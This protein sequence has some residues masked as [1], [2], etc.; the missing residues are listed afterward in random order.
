[1]MGEL[2]ELHWRGFNSLHSFCFDG[3]YYAGFE[4]SERQCVHDMANPSQSLNRDCKAFDSNGRLIHDNCPAD[5]RGPDYCRLPLCKDNQ[6]PGC[7][8]PHRNSTVLSHWFYL[9]SRGAQSTNALQCR[10][11]VKPLDPDPVRSAKQ[12]ARILF[13]SMTEYLFDP[14]TGYEGLAHA[15]IDM[16]KETFA[17]EPAKVRSVVE[18]WY[19]VNVIQESFFEAMA[20]DVRPPREER[21]VYPWIKFEWPAGDLEMS[22]DFEISGDMHSYQASNIGDYEVL[23]NG[24]KVGVFRLALPFNT[25]DRYFWRTR[26]SSSDAW[27]DCHPIHSFAGTT[28]P[29]DIREVIVGP[30]DDA[31]DVS[32]G[33]VDVRWTHV[34]GAKRYKVF[35]ARLASHAEDPGCQSDA[36][37]IEE[38]FDRVDGDDP[39]MPEFMSGT[40]HKIQ[41]EE[42]YWINVQPIGPE[43]FDREPSRGPCYSAQFRTGPMP[44]PKLTSPE[45]SERWKYGSSGPFKWTAEGEPEQYELRFRDLDENENCESDVI[46]DTVPDEATEWTTSMFSPVANGTGYCWDVVS[47]AENGKKSPPSDLQKLFYYF[48]HVKPTWPGVPIDRAITERFSVHTAAN[49]SW[50]PVP[51]AWKYVVKLGRWP[52]ANPISPPDPARCGNDLGTPVSCGFGPRSPIREEVAGN[53]VKLGSDPGPGRY[54]WTVWPI[55]ED[56]EVQ[57]QAWARQPFVDPYPQ[58]CFATQA[59]AP[60]IEIFNRPSGERFSAA[61]IRGRATAMFVPD[62]HFRVLIGEMTTG[63]VTRIDPDSVDCAPEARSAPFRDMYNCTIPFSITPREGEQYTVVARTWDDD[64]DDP[65]EYIDWFGWGAGCYCQIDPDRVHE[66]KEVFHTGYCGREG[67]A[68]CDGGNC[69]TPNSLACRNGSCVS[70][71]NPGQAC[72]GIGWCADGAACNGT[73]AMCEACGGLGQLCCGFLHCGS[74]QR[75]DFGTN[76]CVVASCGGEGEPCCTNGQECWFGVCAAGTC[77]RQC[78]DAPDGICSHDKTQLLHCENGR[79]VQHSCQDLC[80]RI[81]SYSTGY[82][83]TD[84]GTWTT[85]HGGDARCIGGLR[86]CCECCPYGYTCLQYPGVSY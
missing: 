85:T 8:G 21:Q 33:K 29:D 46:V 64:S 74:G 76:R 13:D 36:D 84:P 82:C 51:Q 60:E 77:V 54:C 4:P 42:D 11:N 48:P 41:P 1:M 31:G 61:H 24:Q 3:D 62:G 68:C 45:D 26:P 73:T 75:C 63:T 17:T 53:T 58:Y 39:W 66:A 35:A 79:T 86:Q 22:W 28:Q 40:L 38:T 81:K 44:K 16:A 7:C 23:P 49:L 25:G 32:P 30:R 83:G 10:Y 65:G 50:T 71:G 37:V 19:A 15:T 2:A 69:K 57:G 78:E 80:S 47:V 20:A 43:D 56:P 6:V 59:T 70:C 34:A 52:W 27:H 55:L 9:L 14:K 72:C 12:A 5:Y 67:E 18:A